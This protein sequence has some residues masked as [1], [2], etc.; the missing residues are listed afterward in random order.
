M[1]QSAGTDIAVVETSFLNT[2][3]DESLGAKLNTLP[4]VAQATPMIFNLMDLT[5]DV[6]ALVYGWRAIPMSSIRLRSSPADAFAMAARSDARRI[7]R[8]QPPQKA[9]RFLPI[10]G[11][12]FAVTGVYHGGTAL[13]A[14]AVIMPLDQLQIISSMEGKLRPFMCGFARPRRRAT[15]RIREER[16]GGDRS[17]FARSPSASGRA[18]RRQQSACELAHSVAWG[19]SSIA[20]LMGIL[21]IATPWPCRS[22]SARARSASC[23]RWA[24]RAGTSS[25]SFLP[26]RRLWVWLAAFSASPWDGAFCA[27]SP[28]CRRPRA[29]FRLPSRLFIYCSRFS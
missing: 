12:T 9:K 23:V 25:C 5:P 19:T 2:S 14:G 7:S 10:Q 13:E 1:Y 26:R 18:A 27:C 20:L 11:T 3:L 17:R 28:P 22:S 21:G 6:N 16:R 8:R 24:G 4:D 29:L 15:R